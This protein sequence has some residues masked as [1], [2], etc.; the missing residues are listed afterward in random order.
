[1][2]GLR[3]GAVLRAVR[4]RKGLRQVDVARLARLSDA[5][6][7]RIERGHLGPVTFGTVAAVAR[8]L[9]VN[10]DHRAW[11]RAGDLD[12]LFNARHAA[13]VD[14]VISS[15]AAK[16]WAA[17]P[18]ISFNARGERGVIDVL[19]WHERARAL[20]VIEV[21]TE[22]VDVGELLGTLD[23]KRRLGPEIARGL[24]WEVA[25][26]S[27][28]LIVG[29]S[30]TNRR[31]VQAHAASLHAALPGDGRQLRGFLSHPSPPVALIAFW[32]NRHPGT[33]RTARRVSSAVRRV[34]QP[35]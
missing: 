30:H 6:I 20:L 3:L 34:R 22:I 35:K 29:Q 32:P 19:A 18:E 15:L 16:G 31:R 8:V 2:D 25:S 4:I 24:G 28:A 7:S 14:D 13:L 5:T 26:T 12:R 17:R 10:L 27:V 11:S 33:A 1:V 21:K 9:E 23:R